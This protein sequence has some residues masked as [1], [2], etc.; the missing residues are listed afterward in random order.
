MTILS[1][2]SGKF[3]HISKRLQVSVGRRKIKYIL[4][5]TGGIVSEKYFSIAEVHPGSKQA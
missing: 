2:E 1:E 5:E 4:T 3:I